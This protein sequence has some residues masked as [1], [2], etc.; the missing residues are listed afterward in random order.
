IYRMYFAGEYKRP[1]ELGWMIFFLGLVLTMISG[2][3]GYLLIWNQRAFWAAKTILTVPV[4]L[5]EL[6]AWIPQIGSQLT[7]GS[8]IALI[9]PG[10]PASRPAPDTGAPLPP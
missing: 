10:G 1:G 8:I 4:Y 2:V 9:L 3:T 7:V 6:T 5:D